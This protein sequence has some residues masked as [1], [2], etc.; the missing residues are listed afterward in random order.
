M[1]R[2]RDM[3]IPFPGDI[4]EIE[5]TIE[6]LGLVE[7]QRDKELCECY[8]RLP[9][10]DK[11][12][13][14]TF[15]ELL[16]IDLKNPDLHKLFALLDHVSPPVVDPPPSLSNSIVL[17]FLLATCRHRQPEELPALFALLQT[18]EFRSFDLPP[19]PDQ[20]NMISPLLVS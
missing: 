15:G 16:R 11:L 8:L 7:S 18:E 1:S 3:K 2:A 13:I 6:K 20:R 4:V 17:L 19:G 12:D 5:R 14:I 10:T 9:G